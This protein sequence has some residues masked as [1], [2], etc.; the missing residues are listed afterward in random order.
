MLTI[1]PDGRDASRPSPA[2]RLATPEDAHILAAAAAR[3]FVDT[4]GAAN[5]P[6][7]MASYLAN[8][9][10]EA[11]QFA[12]LSA[13]DT[14]LLL[15]MDGDDRIAGYV[16]IRLDAPLPPEVS[17]AS[18]PAAEIARLYADRDWHGHGLGKLLM[19][20]AIDIARTAGADVLWLGVW[21][22]NARAIGFY[23]KMGFQIV[24]AK[25]FLLGRDRQR[26]HVMALHLT[27]DG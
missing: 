22:H 5:R 12:E 25:D 20:G 8:E 9:F 23:A 11:R 4:F 3:F 21:E 15:A 6:D 16:H 7:D 10:S 17:I 18:E 1:G 19:D 26:D 13:P 27:S 24:G 2:L 14:R